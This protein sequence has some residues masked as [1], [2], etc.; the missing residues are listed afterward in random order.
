MKPKNRP[1]RFIG[2][3]SWT[4]ADFL[5]HIP[6]PLHR[7]A[8]IL[9]CFSLFFW[10]IP[11]KKSSTIKSKNYYIVYA[12][13]RVGAGSPSDG[14]GLLHTSATSERRN[15]SSGLSASAYHRGLH[16][17]VDGCE[18]RSHHVETMVET[19]VLLAFT[20]ESNHR[21][22][23]VVPCESD[24]ASPSTKNSDAP[25]PRRPEKSTQVLSPKL[26]TSKSPKGTGTFLSLS[27][28][29]FSLFF[30]GM[31]TTSTRQICFIPA[32][33]W[34]HA[35][36]ML[37]GMDFVHLQSEKPETGGEM[38]RFLRLFNLAR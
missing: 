13:C 19:I 36:K 22:S 24:F 34:F 33:M 12:T 28:P 17:T 31:L 21:V 5:V 8:G 25:T 4:D 11:Q 23:W 26:G 20:G 38:S 14:Q 30:F 9:F 7:N 37:Q 29:S 32:F 16:H 6:H 18:I 35:A 1:S 27:R 2:E 10:G 15:S 3:F